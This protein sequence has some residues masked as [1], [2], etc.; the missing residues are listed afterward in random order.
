MSFQ[1]NL[2]HV[3]LQMLYKH[4]IFNSGAK[5]ENFFCISCIHPRKTLR[6]IFNGAY[7]SPIQKNIC[8][9]FQEIVRMY[10]T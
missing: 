8:A 4:F 1:G 10:K 5:P 2:D 7:L 6:N 9:L 3:F